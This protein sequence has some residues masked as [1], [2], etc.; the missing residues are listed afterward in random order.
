MRIL[1]VTVSIYI[2][3]IWLRKADVMECAPGE[4]GRGNSRKS[5]AISQG[6]GSAFQKESQ[7]KKLYTPKLDWGGRKKFRVVTPLLG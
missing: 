5:S 6:G 1:G 3:R 7:I 4:G 2:E